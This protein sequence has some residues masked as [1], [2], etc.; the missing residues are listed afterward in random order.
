MAEA[1]DTKQQQQQIRLQIQTL[2]G[3]ISELQARWQALTSTS[4]GITLKVAA[5]SSNNTL[6]EDPIELPT[7]QTSG[8]SRWQTISLSSS[9]ESRDS[10]ASAHS[11][12]RVSLL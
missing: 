4:G 8:G 3:E 12:A 9:K 1:T 10:L 11:E 5:S 2:T 7:E 6:P